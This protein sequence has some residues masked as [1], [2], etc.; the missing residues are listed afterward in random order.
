MDS[1]TTGT[2]GGIGISTPIGETMEAIIIGFDG[3][4]SNSVL[5]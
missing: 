1:V 3:A 4:G 5:T 2:V